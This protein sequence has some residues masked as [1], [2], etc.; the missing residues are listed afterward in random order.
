MSYSMS[1]N[2]QGKQSLKQSQRLMMS[3]QMQQAI[4]LLQ[5]PQLELA[6]MVDAELEQNPL[7]EYSSESSSEEENSPTEEVVNDL[8]EVKE[9]EINEDDFSIMKQLDDEWRDHFSESGTVR[10]TRTKEDN[11]LQSFLENSIVG[12]VDFFEFLMKQAQEHFE[13]PQDLMMAEELIGNLDEKGFL[14]ASLEEIALLNDFDQTALS[15][16]LDELQRFEPYGVGAKNLKES[17]LIQLSCVG[18]KRS[19]AYQI[20]EIHFE[21]LLSNRIPL[22]VKSLTSSTSEVRAA[23][24]TDI[25]KLNLH[26]GTSHKKHQVQHV[27]PDVW[28]TEENGA[29]IVSVHREAM[30]SLRLNRRYL[31]M[32]EQPDMSEEDK[33]YIRNKVASGKWLLK[34]IHQ[35]NESIRRITEVLARTH[36]EFFQHPEGKLQPLTMKVIAEELGLHES[37]IARAVSNKYVASP[38]G[39][40]P[41]RSFF[42]NAYQSDKGEDVSS[43]TVKE[44]LYQIIELENKQRPLSDEAISKKLKEEGI[45]CAR[46][47][48]AKYRTLY[49]IGNASQ[50]KVHL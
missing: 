9:V 42:T 24:D 35:R 29:F 26:P 23:I 17:L 4:Q 48:V 37:T 32:L 45:P 49:N 33:E 11:E 43:S 15:Y 27:E 14:E 12:E 46:R 28:I 34:N 10:K 40:L 13:E 36:K 39:L 47:T 5:M 25:V 44:L 22:I 2:L 8:P 6:L 30:P 3:P 20:I 19:L 1:L 21:D 18:K 50:R 41:L 16:V 7:M 38:R 31:N